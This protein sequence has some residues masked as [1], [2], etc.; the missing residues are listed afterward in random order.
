MTHKKYIQ[1][2]HKIVP[3]T[4]LKLDE[5]TTTDGRKD[6]KLK[7]VQHSI[8]LPRPNQTAEINRGKGNG[9]KVFKILEDVSQMVSSQIVISN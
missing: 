9:D 7:W 6:N 4:E 5:N 2:L 3:N 8:T 1:I